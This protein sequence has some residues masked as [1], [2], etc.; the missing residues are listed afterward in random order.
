MWN[1]VAVDK[2][3]YKSPQLVFLRELLCPVRTKQNTTP[4]VMKENQ[5]NQP[6][7]KYLAHHPEKVARNSVLVSIAG[8]LG[9]LQCL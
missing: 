9:S 3:F 2:A 8:R 4:S 5:C 6:D 7:S 1:T